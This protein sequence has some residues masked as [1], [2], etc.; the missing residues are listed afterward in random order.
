MEAVYKL[1]TLN[2]NAANSVFERLR[3]LKGLKCVV[4]QPRGD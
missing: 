2:K 1:L 3:E 4:K